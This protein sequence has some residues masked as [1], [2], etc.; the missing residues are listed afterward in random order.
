[1]KADPA[2]QE[3][4]DVLYLELARA[5][6]ARGAFLGLVVHG[7]AEPVALSHEETAKIEQATRHWATARFLY[8]LAEAHGNLDHKEMGAWKAAVNNV[9]GVE[10][11]HGMRKIDDTEALLWMMEE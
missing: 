6:I 3:E 9:L 5:R 11:M 1:M 7:R 4:W 2:H 8:E 10:N